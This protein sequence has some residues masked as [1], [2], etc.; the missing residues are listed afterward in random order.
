MQDFVSR[1]VFLSSFISA[2][3]MMPLAVKTPLDFSPSPA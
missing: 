1:S 3:G 2:L